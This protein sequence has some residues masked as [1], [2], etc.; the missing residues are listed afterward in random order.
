MRQNEIYNGEVNVGDYTITAIQ[1]VKG[2]LSLLK[3]HL[4]NRDKEPTID[5]AIE[6]VQRVQ[7]DMMRKIDVAI[8]SAE[9]ISIWK[10][11]QMGNWVLCEAK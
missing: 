6:C 2:E 1:Q 8:V 11:G 4:E 7:R 9:Q 10:V 3:I 5:D